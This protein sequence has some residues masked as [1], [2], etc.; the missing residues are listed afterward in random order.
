LADPVYADF[1]IVCQDMSIECHRCILAANSDVFKAMMEF[2]EG[3]EA[4]RKSVKIKDFSLSAVKAMV[5]FFYGD[6]ESV[7][8]SLE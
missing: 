6:S 4:V 1:R 8:C 5:H 2:K 7:E 3:T